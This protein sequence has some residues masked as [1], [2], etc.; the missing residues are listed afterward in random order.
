MS[1]FRNS[2]VANK[3]HQDLARKILKGHIDEM[4]NT[5]TSSVRPNDISFKNEIV[6]ITVSPCNGSY[7]VFVRY[8]NGFVPD[9]LENESNTKDNLHMYDH[10]RYYDERVA[11]SVTRHLKKVVREIILSKLNDREKYMFLSS[12]D[13]YL[14]SE[15][16]DRKKKLEYIKYMLN[17]NKKAES[18]G[19]PLDK[20]KVASAKAFIKLY[21]E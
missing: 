19:F 13:E 17:E 3:K 15:F 14:A 9:Y 21:D 2:K 10:G 4:L 20:V 18:I 11:P 8:I 1:N 16:E 12:E 6:D 5:Y 7:T